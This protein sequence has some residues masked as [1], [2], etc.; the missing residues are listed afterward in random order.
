MYFIIYRYYLDN[1]KFG[2]VDLARFPDIGA[3]YGI[4]DSYFVKQLPTLILFKD[5][6]PDMIKPSLDA[7]KRI[8]KFHMNLD[9]IIQTFGLNE[10]YKECKT[11]LTQ[12][13]K[14]SKKKGHDK[15]D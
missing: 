1:L 10:L 12:K 13:Q 14:T 15:A 3:E 11:G 9:N 5:G 4:Y 2:K 7:N 8:I 6:K